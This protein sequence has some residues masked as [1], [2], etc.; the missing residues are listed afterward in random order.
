[1][2]HHGT[3]SSFEGVWCDRSDVV[4]EALGFQFGQLG[5]HVATDRDDMIAFRVK[6]GVKDPVAVASLKENLFAGFGINGPDRV[7]GTTE[8]NFG[9]VR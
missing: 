7:V 4:D 9:P 1:M 5:S 3:H 2:H 6:G 8:G